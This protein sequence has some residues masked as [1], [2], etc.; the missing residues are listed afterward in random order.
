MDE[1]RLH[2]TIKQ[3]LKHPVAYHRIFARVGGGATAGLMLS[4]AWYWSDKGDDGWFYK[5]Q[6]EWEEETGLTRTEQETAR[7]NLREKGLLEEKRAGMPARL[8]FR[9]ATERLFSLIAENP[10][11]SMQETR[12]QEAAK[13]TGKSA[14]N[15]QSFNKDTETT[16]EITA[17]T[18]GRDTAPANF[19]PAWLDPTTWA[20]WIAH[21]AETKHPVTLQQAQ[22]QF[23]KL[24]EF[25]ARGMPPEKVIEQSLEHGWQ[26]LFEL[27]SE[28][29]A[30]GQSNNQP[31]TN[32][33][34]K[35][36]VTRDFTK[37][38]ARTG[39]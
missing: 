10:Q 35:P 32:Y 20:R 38:P 5:S 1:A 39:R 19:L 16:S 30:N 14:E 23:R 2:T 6:E 9:V 37:Y 22:A 34:S 4:Q 7:R 28:G 21:R 33:G 25:R 11:S 36:P 3:L 12:N 15:P 17:E 13:P 29:K 18:T 24:E 27:K 8:Y 31:R 26:G